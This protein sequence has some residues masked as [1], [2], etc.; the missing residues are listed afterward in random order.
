MKNLLLICFLFL[1]LNGFAQQSASS[2]IN[3]ES[4]PKVE[5]ADQFREDGKIYVLVA[6]MVTIFLGVT[7][8]TVSIDK[9]VSRLEKDLKN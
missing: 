9:K 5:M 8:Y 1:S 6:I 7:V 3:E 4:A 2:M